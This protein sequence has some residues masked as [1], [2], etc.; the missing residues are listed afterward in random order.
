M[1]SKS[2]KI[3]NDVKI[4]K[5]DYCELISGYVAMKRSLNFKDGL[6]VEKQIG[7]PKQNMTPQ[8]LREYSRQ[9]I[10]AALALSKSKGGKR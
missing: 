3:G 5:E 10:R 8:Q 6:E 4:N 9:Y 1:F 7:T 2:V